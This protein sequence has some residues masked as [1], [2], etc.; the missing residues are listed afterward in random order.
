MFPRRQ[1]ALST[2]QKLVV[3][4]LALCLIFILVRESSPATSQRAAAPDSPPPP[5]PAP[6]NHLSALVRP[7]C[8]PL[9][10]AEWKA[11][12]MTFS[13]HE[14]D[15]R[16]KKYL[17][18]THGIYIESGAF[19]GKTASNTY[20]YATQ[21]CWTGLLVEPSARNAAA[22]TVNRPTDIV[23]HSALVGPDFPTKAIRGSFNNELMS[24]VDGA[25]DEEVPAHTITALLEKNG[26]AHVH[27]WSLDVEGF[28][29]DVLRG[30]DFTRWTPDYILL[31]LWHNNSAVKD[32]LA[33]K[34]YSIVADISPWRH[35]SRHRDIVFR[36]AAALAV[37][38]EDPSY[39]T[40]HLPFYGPD[41]EPEGSGG[42][43][44]FQ[45]VTYAS[46][47]AFILILFFFLSQAVG[48]AYCLTWHA[49]RSHC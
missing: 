40:D 12:G 4:V 43:I 35:F 6:G 33:A 26:V 8:V 44:T 29:L 24:K 41:G 7:S 18:G 14:L 28:E 23:E 34:G 31:E 21:R 39:T 1:Y 36:S 30:L 27:W 47:A 46:I 48:T 20:I 10:S 38:A 5:P 3:I 17:T 9:S 15:V 37:Q 32:F 11:S 2:S 19:D 13:Q 25:G 45:R 16:M 42:Y 49:S 22:A